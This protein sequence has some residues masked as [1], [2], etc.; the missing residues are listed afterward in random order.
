[1]GNIIAF[2]LL[3]WVHVL[4]LQIFL[5]IF[6]L[7]LPSLKGSGGCLGSVLLFPFKVAQAVVTGLFSA[8]WFIV[9]TVILTIGQIIKTIV[10]LIGQV[11]QALVLI[12]GKMLQGVF[13][14]LWQ[15]LRWILRSLFH[16]VEFLWY[17]LTY[18]FRS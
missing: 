8:L 9:R 15:V 12:V 14:V 13:W 1:M 16:I 3:L 7:S 17:V 11:L 6:G 2:L 5:G 10:L 18:R 4:L